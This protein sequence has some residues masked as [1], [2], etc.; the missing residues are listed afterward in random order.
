MKSNFKKANQNYTRRFW[1]L[2]VLY[3][4]FCCIGPFLLVFLTEPGKWV[5][6]A[7]AI[8]NVSP[9]PFIFFVMGKYLIETDEYTRAKQVRAMLSGGAFVLSFAATWGFLELYRVLPPFWSFLYVP[10][11][12]GAYGIAYGV[13][14]RVA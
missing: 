10:I 6:A 2:I 1:P 13:R 11:F 7:I 9:I 4:M 8:L 5:Y 12:F 14:S 3:I